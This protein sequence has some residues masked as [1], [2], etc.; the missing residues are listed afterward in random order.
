MKIHSWGNL[1]FIFKITFIVATVTLF[2][3]YALYRAF[4]WTT[5]NQMKEQGGTG[6]CEG[7]TKDH[8]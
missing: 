8:T 4:K 3:P 1:N 5:N 2:L 6:V 7:W